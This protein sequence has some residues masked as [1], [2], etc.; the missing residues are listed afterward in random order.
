MITINTLQISSDRKTLTVDII[1]D[2]GAVFNIVN[3]WTEDTFK[4]SVKAIDL[5]SKLSGSNN[6]ES[7]TIT[8]SDLGIDVFDGLYFIEFGDDNDLLK[9]GSVAELTT[10]KKCLLYG[11]G[12]NSSEFN[13]LI[14]INAILNSLQSAIISGYNGEAIEFINTLKKFC[15]TCSDCGN[16][17]SILSIGTLNNNI[18]LI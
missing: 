1:T 2:S 7:F 3:L 4:D 16:L 8:S 14:Y 9:L 6:T 11:E 18:I 5:S 15:T 10:Y 13:K 12:C 17:N